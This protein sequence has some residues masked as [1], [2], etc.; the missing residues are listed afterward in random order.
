MS[1][2]NK[3]KQKKEI[4]KPEI[5]KTLS[6][7]DFLTIERAKMRSLL[8][9]DWS[10]SRFRRFSH[11]RPTEIGEEIQKKYIE[12]MARRQDIKLKKRTLY[13]LFI[14]LGLETIAIFVFGY[15]QAVGKGFSGVDFNLQEWSFRLLVTATIIQITFMLQVAVKHLFPGR[16]EK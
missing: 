9:N 11:R 7:S 3:K 15:F 14:F 10:N 8:E 5:K 12:N 1:G 2:K 4:S 6:R 13:C 16:G